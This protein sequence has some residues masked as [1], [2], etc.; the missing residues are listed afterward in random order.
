Q[1]YKKNRQEKKSL[2]RFIFFTN[3]NSRIL[4]GQSLA[5]KIQPKNPLER[6]SKNTVKLEFPFNS[7]K[8]PR[9]LSG[10]NLFF[11]RFQRVSDVEACSKMSF[12]TASAV[13]S[14]SV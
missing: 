1:K 4:P 6:W 8:Y 9:L 11:Q 5:K 10:Q 13:L 3:S 7:S 2:C 12:S 14:P